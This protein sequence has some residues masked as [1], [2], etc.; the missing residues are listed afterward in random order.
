M[1]AKDIEALKGGAKY[2]LNPKINLAIQRIGRRYVSEYFNE[3]I[4]VASSAEWK[5][6]LTDTTPK[7]VRTHTS[8]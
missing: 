4:T 1:A 8:C 2:Q 5:I 7:L 6:I 3:Q